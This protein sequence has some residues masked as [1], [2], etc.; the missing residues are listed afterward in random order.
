MKRVFS[1]VQPTGNIHLGNYLGA[2][3]QFVELQEDH[4]CIYCIV[5]EHAITVPQDPKELKQHILDVAALYLAIG[6]DP[7]KSIVFVQSQV[8][9]HAELGWIL[10]CVSNTGELYRMAAGKKEYLSSE[11]FRDARIFFAPDARIE[12]TDT[13]IRSVSFTFDICSPEGFLANNYLLEVSDGNGN[14]VRSEYI[15]YE[16]FERKPNGRIAA[17]IRDL[18]SGTSYVLRVYGINPLYR[19]TVTYEGRLISEP[20]EA[21]FTTKEE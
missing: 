14:V 19:S 12:I 4:E 1:G 9:G 11:R 13:S 7:K 21:E 3:K 17:K 8:S 15:S 6:I 20:L 5:D 10:N 16:Y 2:L 18:S